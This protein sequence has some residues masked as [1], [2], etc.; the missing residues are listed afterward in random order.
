MIDLRSVIV[1]RALAAEEKK[2][3]VTASDNVLNT[4]LIP[5]EEKGIE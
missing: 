1:E 2:V 5:P 4:S 3:A